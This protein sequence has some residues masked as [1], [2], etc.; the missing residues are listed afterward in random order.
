MSL[1]D[2]TELDKRLLQLILKYVGA[3]LAYAANAL[4]QVPPTRLPEP[5]RHAYDCQ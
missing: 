2:L 1:A 5:L 3:A 4:K